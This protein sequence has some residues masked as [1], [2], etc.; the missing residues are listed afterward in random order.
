MSV[1]PWYYTRFAAVTK[2][3]ST[4]LTFRG[5]YVGGAGDV[6]VR[7]EG[8]TDGD[9]VTFKAVPVG[10]ILPIAGDKVMNATTATLILALT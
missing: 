10:T 5:L 9:A 6:V 3:D 7:P 1:G 2:S 8:L 4:V